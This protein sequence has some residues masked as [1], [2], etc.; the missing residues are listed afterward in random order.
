MKLL[1][2]IL[3]TASALYAAINRQASNQDAKVHDRSPP[4]EKAQWQVHPSGLRYRSSI[5]GEIGMGGP[6]T[7]Q[8]WFDNGVVMGDG[9][10]YIGASGRWVACTDVRSE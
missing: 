7:Y 8:H 9:N 3:N 6:A 2:S 10:L 5:T 1:Q 4:I